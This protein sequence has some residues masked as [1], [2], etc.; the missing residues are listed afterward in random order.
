MRETEN[1][2]NSVESAAMGKE[3]HSLSNLIMRFL[4]AKLNKSYV[5]SA[6][7]ANTW[8]L[9]YIKCNGSRQVFQRD[10]EKEFCITRS[11]ASK[12]VVLME[13]KGFIRRERVKGDGRLKRLV[14]TDK[15]E[16]ILALIEEDKTVIEQTLSKGFSQKEIEEFC[17]YIERIKA[18][19][20]GELAK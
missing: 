14:L 15:G 20:Q 6:T 10:I 2:R 1:V 16:H 7:G 4:S 18:N 19:L 17:G 8:I 11:T 12:V 5:E 9:K 3:I 13:K